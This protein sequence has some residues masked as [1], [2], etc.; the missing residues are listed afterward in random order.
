MGDMWF[1][2]RP[3]PGF[4]E[5]ICEAKG[6]INGS[7]LVRAGT[8]VLGACLRLPCCFFPGACWRAKAHRYRNLSYSKG[9]TS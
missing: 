7:S 3:G 5:H 2:C 1:F 9:C 6:G 4:G 8:A